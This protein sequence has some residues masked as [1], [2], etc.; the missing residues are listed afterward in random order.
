MAAVAAEAALPREVASRESELPRLNGPIHLV[1]PLVRSM[2]SKAFAGNIHIV[3]AEIT[4]GI[5]LVSTDAFR[6][7]V[8]LRTVTL[9]EGIESICGS[10]FRFCRNLRE[11]V[12]PSTLRR[13]G[14]AA[15]EGCT[16]LTSVAI[17][18]GVTMIREHAF[19]HCSHLLV[20]TIPNP[21]TVFDRGILDKG[22]VF[23]GC[24]RLQY[25]VAPALVRNP[26]DHF[27]DTRVLE[28]NGVV[29]DSPRTRTRAH[30]LLY[31]GPSSHRLCSAEQRVWV[32]SVLLVAERLS[33]MGLRLP[34]EL[35][36][37]I[38]RSFRLT[39]LP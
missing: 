4:A 24:T 7:C 30:A 28:L 31:W 26:F 18:P 23:E 14:H 27:V 38:L 11:I 37:L 21:D 34:W 20:A 8:N 1:V 39:D 17:P 36:L 35:W 22:R 32:A 33:R 6:E 16:R 29:E 12:L 15:F 5:T 19:S 3:S 13:I 25:V 10:A 9:P 2:R